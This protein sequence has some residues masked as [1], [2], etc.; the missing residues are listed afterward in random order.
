MRRIIERNGWKEVFDMYF[1]ICFIFG[2]S[3]ALLGWIV[4]LASKD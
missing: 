4:Y 1:T 3:I 2:G